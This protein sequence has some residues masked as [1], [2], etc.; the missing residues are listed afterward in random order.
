MGSEGGGGREGERQTDRNTETETDRDK[1]T[2][3]ERKRNLSS[4]NYEELQPRVMRW[5]QPVLSSQ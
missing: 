4:P 1:E 5:I 2:E 3:K